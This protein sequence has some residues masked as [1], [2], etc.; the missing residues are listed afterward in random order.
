MPKLSVYICE[1]K[2]GARTKDEILPGAIGR[3]FTL[4]YS[5]DDRVLTVDDL[6]DK[7]RDKYKRFFPNAP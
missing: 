6:F 1:R 5:D 7:V 2:D 4:A 3:G